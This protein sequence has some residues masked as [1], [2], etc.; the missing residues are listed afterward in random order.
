RARLAAAPAL[1]RRALRVR[2]ERRARR[3][4]PA[5]LHVSHGR[6]AAA[7][8]RARAAARRE[9]GHGQR[10]AV[11]AAPP[12]AA[13]G[14]QRRDRRARLPPAAQP[15][16]RPD[17]AQ[18]EQG[19]EHESEPGHEPAGEPAMSAAAGAE[20]SVCL[21]TYDHAPVVESTLAS[22]LAQ[23]LRGFELIVSDDGSTDGTWELICRRAAA[24]ARITAVRTPRNL[25]MPG[26]A[27]FAARR[28]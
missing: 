18:G 16:R 6:R 7:R 14:R 8:R 17:L 3:H 19:A 1:P 4:P 24:D 22:V 21:L 10:A 27:N 11:V 20:I 28:S 23:S 5:L 13:G 15:V 25:G 2:R 12:A 26:N 9:A